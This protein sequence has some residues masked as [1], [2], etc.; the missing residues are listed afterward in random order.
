VYSF[1]VDLYL[2]IC[3][4]SFHHCVVFFLLIIV[5]F[6]VLFF[7]CVIVQCLVFINKIKYKQWWLT[8]HYKSLHKRVPIHMMLEIQVMAWD[9]QV[10]RGYINS[11]MGSPTDINKQYKPVQIRYHSKSP[12]T[13]ININGSMNM[14]W[15]FQPVCTLT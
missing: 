14:W 2:P 5:L 12:H 15:Y 11:L 1:C 7:L 6:F 4:I 3:Q 13:I 10:W 8:I 9:S